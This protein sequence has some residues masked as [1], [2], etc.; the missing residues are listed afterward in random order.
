MSNALVL[1]IKIILIVFFK[2]KN[3]WNCDINADENALKLINSTLSLRSNSIQD[4]GLP[5]ISNELMES[6]DDIYYVLIIL[7][8]KDEHDR[9]IQLINDKSGFMWQWKNSSL[10]Y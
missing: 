7:I 5:D 2:L 10:R 1:I 9:R 6:N 4:F 8:M 3:T